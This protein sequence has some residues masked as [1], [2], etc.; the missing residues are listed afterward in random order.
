M[1]FVGYMGRYFTNAKIDEMEI[2]GVIDSI[3][4]GER[5]SYFFKVENKWFGF[6]Y[7]SDALSPSLAVGD[8]LVKPLRDPRMVLYRKRDSDFDSVLTYSFY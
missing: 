4:V 3:K 7:H 6:G 1:V 5:Q 8:S 2:Y